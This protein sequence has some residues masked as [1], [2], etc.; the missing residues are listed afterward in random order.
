MEHGTWKERVAGNLSAFVFLII[1]VGNKLWTIC[2]VISD[3]SVLKHI[4]I[5]A[6]NLTTVSQFR[7]QG[8]VQKC[9]EQRRFKCKA[10]KSPNEHLI[11]CVCSVLGSGYAASAPG[12][13]TSLFSATSAI[14]NSRICWVLVPLF[15]S[16]KEQWRCPQENIQLKYISYFNQKCYGIRTVLHIFSNSTVYIKWIKSELLPVR[17]C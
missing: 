8:A 12:C 1:F 5:L 14:F 3:V 2:L 10:H 13:N 9:T 4:S 15:W 7:W 11:S 16:T 6:G 17:N